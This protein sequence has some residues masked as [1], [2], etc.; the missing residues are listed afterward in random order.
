MQALLRDWDSPNKNMPEWW[1]DN[2][3]VSLTWEM[4]QELYNTG[5]NVMVLHTVGVIVAF[6]RLPGGVAKPDVRMVVYV[7]HGMF[8]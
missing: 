5:N 7:H 1:E 8:L 3:V 6:P 4:I 2:E